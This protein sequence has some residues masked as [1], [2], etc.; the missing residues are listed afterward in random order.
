MLALAAPAGFVRHATW[1]PGA[2]LVPR[3]DGRLLVGAT[4]EPAGFDERVTARGMHELLHAALSA[5]PS[6]R[7][8]A[9]TESWAGLRPGTPDGLPFL[10]PTPIA[11]FF[12]A[13]GH[14]RNGIL[15]APAT[16]A[17]DG[18][19]DRK[20]H[21]SRTLGPSRSTAG[22][23]EESPRGPNHLRVKA[24]INGASAR[25]AR[26]A[27]GQ[28]PAR[29]AGLAPRRVRRRSQRSRRPASG[30]RH[31][32]STRRRPSRNYHRSGGR[33]AWK[34]IHC[35]SARWNLRRASSSEPESI[36]RWK[37]CRRRMRPAARRW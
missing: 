31:G 13:C 34:R 26:G 28:R 20:Q 23:R 5:A 30:V 25:P 1:V 3:D 17:L 22:A 15:L 36:R 35:A 29:A 9:V 8:F 4:V 37:S 16:R 27:H 11:G 10:G 6:L 33:L 12:L 21:D 24:T 32:S 2:Y 7:S 18:R 14:Y 19:C